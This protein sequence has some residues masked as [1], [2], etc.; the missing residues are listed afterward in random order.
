MGIVRRQ[1]IYNTIL[2]Y[3]GIGIGFLSKVLI[4]YFLPLEEYGMLGLLT[5]TMVIGS[6]LSQFGVARLVYRFFPHYKRTEAGEGGFTTFVII[7]TLAGYLVAILLVLLLKPA[8][9][10]SFGQN[11]PL[12]ASQFY[13]LIPA[14]LAHTLYRVG[15]AFARSHLRSVLPTFSQE[16]LVRLSQMTMVALYAY[17]HISFQGFVMGY[18]MSF[19]LSGTIIIGYLVQQGKV[20]ISLKLGYLRPRVL[21][22]LLRYCLLTSLA[23]VAYFIVLRVD[24][25]MIGSLIGEAAAG[26]Y[27]IAYYLVILLLT[28][29]RSMASITLPLFSN[30][31]KARRMDEV[32]KLHLR[33]SATSLVLA[34]LI[35]MLMYVNSA[36][37]FQLLPKVAEARSV[38]LYLGLGNLSSALSMGL[39]FIVIN[40][41]HYKFDLFTNILL[42]AVV[43]ASNLVM[44]PWMGIDGAAIATAGSLI[45]YNGI[46]FFFAWR[47][48]GIQSLTRQTFWTLLLG[49]GSLWLGLQIPSLANPWLDMILRTA[50]M[51]PLYLGIALALRLSPDLNDAARLALKKVGLNQG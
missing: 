11:S 3:T 29:A 50:I 4:L 17:K 51:L 15:E 28:P 19:F 49:A 25:F 45:L 33:S 5:S 46:T 16:V 41:R 14:M 26:T 22:V 42:I 1:S 31:L 20:R 6:E 7:Y 32:R 37:A 44:I 24:Q 34:Q 18:M 9:L 10:A 13:L 43:V 2:I 21:K 39:R 36:A 23:F 47:T 8:L 35:F 30:H 38:L 27:D 12:F 48:F 40:S